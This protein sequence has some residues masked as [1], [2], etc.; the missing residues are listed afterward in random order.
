ML[1]MT[2]RPHLLSDSEIVEKIKNQPE[3][4][5]LDVIDNEGVSDYELSEI[6]GLSRIRIRQIIGFEK[7]RTGA[8]DKLISNKDIHKL[9]SYV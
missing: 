8:L 3:S 6:L 7:S 4:C 9:E 1:W 2:W 5:T